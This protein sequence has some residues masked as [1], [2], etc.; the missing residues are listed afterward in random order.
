MIGS[1]LRSLHR[2][3]YSYRQNVL[4]Q[5]I[6]PHLKPGDRVLD[7]GCGFGHLGRALMDAFPD[8][9]VEGVESVKREG[10]LIPITAYE[11]TRMPWDDGVFDVVILADVLHHDKDPQ[12]LLAEAVRVS[13]RLV[14]IKD[15]LREG[16]LAQKRISLLDWAANAGYQV[17]CTYRYNNLAEWRQAIARVGSTFVEERTSINVYPPLFNNLLGGGLHYWAVFSR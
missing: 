6:G 7:A 9:H 10:E 13:R 17:P 15:H 12:R 16:F 14:I 3:I 4:V 2:P 5:M 11:G 1:L 8:V